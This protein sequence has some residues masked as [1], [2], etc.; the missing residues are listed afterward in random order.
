[1]DVTMRG[2][3]DGHIRP[4]A[5]VGLATGTAPASYFQLIRPGAVLPRL[6]AWRE[7]PSRRCGPEPA[8]RIRR[9]ECGGTGCSSP[10]SRCGR[11]WK[12][13]CEDVA[14]RPVALTLAVV[15]ALT[16]L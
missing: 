9:S 6:W 2:Q 10:W 15:I 3:L 13:C 7:T 1:M 16:L 14:W 4:P 12:R 8:L 5:W 11:P